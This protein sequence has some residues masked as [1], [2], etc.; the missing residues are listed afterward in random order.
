MQRSSDTEV[1]ADPGMKYATRRFK[2]ATSAG[3]S[4]FRHISSPPPAPPLPDFTEPEKN[5]TNS[6]ESS[7]EAHNETHQ[8]ETAIAKESSPTPL[9]DDESSNQDPSSDSHPITEQVSSSD[10]HPITDQLTSSDSN[11]IQTESS[12]SIQ[13]Q[14]PNQPSTNSPTENLSPDQTTPITSPQIATIIIQEPAEP[15]PPQTPDS[16]QLL[17]SSPANVLPEQQDTQPKNTP[18]LLPPEQLGSTDKKEKKQKKEKKETKDKKEKKHKH[19]SKSPAPPITGN[20]S[21]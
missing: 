20:I 8:N 17:D 7:S 11:P 5:F 13:E 18:H 12:I 21:A 15:A 14:A 16:V 4:S 19:R 1:P 2:R 6:A 9:P 10:S 3:K